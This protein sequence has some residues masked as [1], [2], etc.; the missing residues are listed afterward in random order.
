[1][2]HDYLLDT[3]VLLRQVDTQSVQH[4]AAAAT[5]RRLIASG[6][7]LFITAQN[8]I[9]FWAVATRPVTANGLGKSTEEASA[10]F[11]ALE[12][13][14]GVVQDSADIFDEWRDLVVKYEVKGKTTHDARL[15]AVMKDAHPHFQYE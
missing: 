14:F 1:M 2:S 4:A 5:I 8:L 7:V 9:E 10:L 6:D 13:T 3:S 12:Q 15:V 11:T